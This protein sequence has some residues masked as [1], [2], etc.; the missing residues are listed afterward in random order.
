[1]NLW[2]ENKED[3]TIKTGTKERFEKSGVYTL[4]I[5]EAYITHSGSSKATGLTL[6]MENDE[7][8]ARTTL[9]YIKGD[10]N[11]NKFAERYLNRMLFLMKT[12]M[13]SVKTE[14]KK[15]K[16]FDGKEVD[17]TFLTSIEGKNIGVILEVKH[18]E[19][20]TN[21][22]VKDFFDIASGKTSDEITNNTDATTVKFFEEK[23]K[24][25]KVHTQEETITETEEEFP[26]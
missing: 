26:F 16:T 6:N 9:W 11:P 23:F 7:G 24:K 2:N 4:T 13:S 10:G 15:V 20:R 22:E 5:K 1:M 3:L 17:R 19:D 14:T 8:T 25:E 18:D 21:Y 12:K